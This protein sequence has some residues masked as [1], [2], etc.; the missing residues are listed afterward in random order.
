[1]KFWSVECLLS[2]KHCVF[3]FR[4][5]MGAGRSWVPWTFVSTKAAL[6]GLIKD[7]KLWAVIAACEFP[8]LI[9]LLSYLP[10]LL[11]PLLSSLANSCFSFHS[12]PRNCP[13][14]GFPRLP[15]PPQFWL[16]VPLVLP[17][18]PLPTP[19]ARAW[20]LWRHVVFTCL[21][22]GILTGL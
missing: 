14:G 21:D 7:G 22:A 15:P 13:L 4:V 17:Q 10:P 12:Q 18:P 6:H 1:M 11:P 8:C 5:W 20:P 19:V 16:S 9:P 2:D 3:S